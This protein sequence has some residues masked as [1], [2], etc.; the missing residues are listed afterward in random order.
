VLA[1]VYLL[2]CVGDQ[3]GHMMAGRGRQICQPDDIGE[4]R[5]GRGG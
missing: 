4:E 3:M 5:R 2:E 1:H